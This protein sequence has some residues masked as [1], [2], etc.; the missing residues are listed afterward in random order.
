MP[1]PH[2]SVFTGRTP[3]LLPNQQF[4]STEANVVSYWLLYI[5]INT[6]NLTLHVTYS[7]SNF[8]H[9]PC[10]PLFSLNWLFMDSDLDPPAN[11]S[12][13]PKRHH[14]RSS[15]FCRA[16]SHDQQT[17]RSH[18]SVCSNRLHQLA[19]VKFCVW[20]NL[21]RCPYNT[22]HT[23]MWVALQCEWNDSVINL[24]YSPSA[25]PASTINFAP[26]RRYF[27]STVASTPLQNDGVFF[28]SLLLKYQHGIVPST[29][30][31]KIHI[32]H[33]LHIHTNKMN[34]DP[35]WQNQHC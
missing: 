9:V 3:F 11:A 19:M 18:N 35:P 29:W 14:D 32:H 7:Y 4:Q 33:C 2:H 5:T 23:T 1:V 34:S 15:R 20:I 28:S 13:Y 8:R 27:S 30:T 21:R 26:S 16:H 24:G 12:Q 10:W 25:V 6:S 22:L 31:Q 17:D